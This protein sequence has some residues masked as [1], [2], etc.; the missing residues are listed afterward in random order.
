M[1]KISFINGNTLKLLAALFMLIDHIGVVLFPRVAILRYIGRLSFPIFA[2]MLSEGTKY[3]KN[4]VNHI[5]GVSTLALLCQTVYY[6]YDKS[7]YMSILV[8]FSLSIAIIYTMQNFKRALFS[9]NKGAKITSLWLFAFTV[10]ISYLFTCF[11]TVDYGFTG[12]LIPVLASVFDF[13]NTDAPE[14]LKK[15]DNIPVRVFCLG[16]GLIINAMAMTSMQYYALL[17]IPV[18][19]LY[20]GKRGKLNLKYFFYV[21]YPLHLLAIEGVAM[22]I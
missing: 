14:S 21:F 5:L 20:S 7:L 12:I 2:F 3:T 1:S 10:L 15:L 19:L 9:D 11:F 22:L 13:R 16:I 4:K 8:T 6:F 18:L 17:S